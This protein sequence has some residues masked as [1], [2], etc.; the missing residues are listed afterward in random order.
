MACGLSTV[1]AFASAVEPQ[2]MPMS[3]TSTEAIVQV[4][5]AVAGSSAGLAVADKTAEVQ[6]AVAKY[7]DWG[8]MAAA[9]AAIARRRSSASAEVDAVP[10]VVNKL[11]FDP[12]VDYGAHQERKATDGGQ[13][14]NRSSSSHQLQTRV[15]FARGGAQ[16]RPGC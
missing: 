10:R 11:P 6:A 12:L 15:S 5:A 4:A 2:P 8:S 1:F 3:R 9:A 16:Q 7:A 13:K 14:P